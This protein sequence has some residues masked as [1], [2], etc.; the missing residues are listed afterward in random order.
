VC[1]DPE[2]PRNFAPHRGALQDQLPF[3]PPVTEALRFSVLQS[4]LG[5]RA[6]D[7][8]TILLIILFS[9]RI[10]RANRFYYF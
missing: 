3:P 1:G 4:N 7:N 6:T 9:L 2:N 5:R 8:L 10:L